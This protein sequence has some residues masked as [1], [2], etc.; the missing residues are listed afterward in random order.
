MGSVTPVFNGST[1]IR[2][3]CFFSLVELLWVE[4]RSAMLGGR[5]N[6]LTNQDKSAELCRSPS[7]QPLTNSSAAL[8]RCPEQSLFLSRSVGMS[9]NRSVAQSMNRN[10]ARSMNRNAVHAMN[11]NVVISRSQ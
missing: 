9:L 5:N 8:S 6:V 2:L 10:V 7:L 1:C 3:L 11:R 4:F